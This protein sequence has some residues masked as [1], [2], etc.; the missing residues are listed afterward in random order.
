MY[1]NAHSYIALTVKTKAYVRY[2]TDLIQ[3]Q[4]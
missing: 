3:V 4:V 2:R 1:G